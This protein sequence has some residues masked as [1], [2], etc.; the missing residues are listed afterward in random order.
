[1]PVLFDEEKKKFLY[2]A[3]NQDLVTSLTISN[4]MQ[5]EVGKILD[6]LRDAGYEI[7]VNVAVRR[8]E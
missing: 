5:S 4:V 6:T 3:T 7:E 2:Q 8:S 1:M